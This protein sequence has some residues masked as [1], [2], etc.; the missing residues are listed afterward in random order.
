MTFGIGRRRF[1]AAL[2]SSVAATSLW[3]PLTAS[4]QQDDRMR[5]I[6]V[7][8]VI[9]ETDPEAKDFVAALETGLAAA[10]W[11]KGRNIEIAYRWGAVNP[12]LLSRYGNELAQSMPDVLVTNGTAALLSFKNVKTIPIVFSAVSDPVAQ[13]FVASLAHPGGNM[14]GFSNYEPNIGGKWLQLLKEVA[15][16]LTQVAVMFN[17][18]IAPYN[19]LWM[20]SIET[21]APGFGVS[22]VQTSVK[23]TDD[24]RGAIG[25]FAAKP[26]AGL[27]VPSD[28]FAYVNTA[29]IAS[30]AAD[31]KLPSIY[32][33]A[34]FAHEG[35]LLAYGVDLVDQ[36]R[37]VADYVSRILKGD[38]P[39]DLPVQGPTRYTLTINLKTAKALGLTV[40][41]GLIA[42]A[43]EVIE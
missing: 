2:G 14:T 29:L 37:N 6:G 4:A 39:A 12:E 41:P 20:H 5:R 35:G 33:Y 40:A 30:L 10:G 24:I 42:A 38:K 3:S 36:F 26:G 21:A 17:P 34:R 7:L 1:I 11:H 23:T 13:G 18:Q 31:N 8:M 9:A 43:D 32:A 27:I 16:T 15:P 19:T 25:S 28:S 22:V